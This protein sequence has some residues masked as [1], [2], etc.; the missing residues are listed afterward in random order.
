MGI[1][2]YLCHDAEI[3]VVRAGDYVQVRRQ[4][5]GRRYPRAAAPAP[6]HPGKGGKA[7]TR[8]DQI[9]WLRSELARHDQPCRCRE[10]NEARGELWYFGADEDATPQAVERAA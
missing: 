2:P 4:G 7:M 10:C 8:E 9:A 6:F 5:A 1:S 3:G